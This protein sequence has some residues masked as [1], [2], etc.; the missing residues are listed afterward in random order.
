V[1]TAPTFPRSGYCARRPARSSRSSRS[2]ARG[3]LHLVTYRG[4][5]LGGDL[6]YARSDDG[7]ASFTVPLRVNHDD[8]DAVAIGNVRGAQLALGRQQGERVVVHVAW[9]GAAGAKQRGPG[10]QAPMLYA[11]R[12]S[13]RADAAFEPERNVIGAHPGLDGGGTLAADG[14]GRVYVAWHAPRHAGDV[15]EAQ[16]TVWVAA[17]TDDGATFGARA[18]RRE[19]RS[20]APAP[21]AACG[22]AAP[23]TSCSCSIARR[24]RASIAT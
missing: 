12:D 3:A 15:D 2:N 1:R 7:G 6:W 5:P 18:R 4:D 22:P 11:R 24:A 21:A 8:G 23:A 16:R 10:N 9:M 14:A 17:S 20:G 19:R 13:A